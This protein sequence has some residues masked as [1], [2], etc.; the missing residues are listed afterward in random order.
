MKILATYQEFFFTKV[1]PAQSITDIV[2]LGFWL[3]LLPG[4]FISSYTTIY[5]FVNNF[6]WIFI[7]Q[8]IR[9]SNALICF[10]VEEIGYSLSMY[11]TRGMEESKMCTGAYRERGVSR[12][13]CTYTLTPSLF[14]FLSYGV[15]CYLQNFN[16]M[17]IQKGYVCQKWLFF[18]Y[19][20]NF[21]CNGISLFFTLNCFSEPKL[22]KTLLILIK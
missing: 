16:L 9:Y 14:M 21:C 15:L 7:F 1:D 5:F 17:F 13:M 11:V 19:E 2:L 10:L 22:A 3:I 6:F 20:I 18:S 8:W 4:M 12:L